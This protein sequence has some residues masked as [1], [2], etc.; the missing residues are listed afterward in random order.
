MKGR[1]KLPALVLSRRN[2][3]EADRLVTFFTR[4]HGLIRAV[5][6]G[7][8]KIPSRRGGHLEPYT[9]ALALLTVSRAGAYVGAVETLNHFP[10][11]RE[12]QSAMRVAHHITTTLLGLFEEGDAEPQLFDAVTEAWHMLPSLPESKA[13]VLEATLMSLALTQAGMM[14]NLTACRQCGV[15]APNESIILDPQQGGWRCLLCHGGFS[16]TRYSMQPALLKVLR[17]IHTNPSQALRVSLQ[18]DEAAQM[19]A[20]MR[21]YVAEVTQQ[22]S[23]GELS[24][25]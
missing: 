2:V 12:S 23:L 21:A 3:G 17:F 22:P 4:E 1:F 16:G 9:L 5:A 11:L 14:P 6:K 25:G 7:V 24:Y 18:Q 8:R 20:G 15:R 19:I 10:E 13:H